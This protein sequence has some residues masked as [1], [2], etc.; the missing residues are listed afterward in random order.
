MVG[1]ND[2]S[3]CVGL[4]RLLLRLH[5]SIVPPIILGFEV[6]DTT[7]VR[8]TE[9]VVDSYFLA[10]IVVTFRTCTRT[11]RRNGSRRTGGCSRAATCSAGLYRLVSSVPWNEVEAA[12]LGKGSDERFPNEVLHFIR[13][14][15]LI[16]VARP[17]CCAIRLPGARV[18][19]TISP[20]LIKLFKLLGAFF[21]TIHFLTCAY[22]RLSDAMDRDRWGRS[23]FPP[24]HQLIGAAL[25]RQ[26]AYGF[27]WVILA[28]LGNAPVDGEYDQC[29]FAIVCTIIGVLVYAF[30]VGTAAGLLS[31]M[32]ALAVEKKEKMDFIN[33][34]MMVKKLPRK[35]QDKVRAYYDYVFAST[36]RVTLSQ[37][38]DAFEDLPEPL[39]LR[40]RLL[41]NAPSL[42][43]TQIFNGE[44]IAPGALEL[45]ALHLR[46][47][48]AF[49]GMVIVRERA[50]MDRVHFPHARLRA[51]SSATAS[52]T[53]ST[54]R[55]TRVALADRR[56]EAAA[57]TTAP[58]ARV[59]A[60]PALAHRA[61]R[62]RRAARGPGS[63][64]P[65]ST[66]RLQRRHSAARR[67]VVIVASYHWRE[68]SPFSQHRG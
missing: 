67:R 7:S 22:W 56:A 40:L 5:S 9:P 11:P 51:L 10:D 4:H 60:R 53:A 47:L 42:R 12:V 13:L 2:S 17:C 18:P 6:P 23:D 61:A 20:S 14:L 37:E 35:L 58:T 65:T 21:L 36:G 49:K 30:I 31:E 64:A 54:T 34:Y 19:G 27:L 1:E 3:T 16:K 39:A 25:K 24:P 29:V 8:V 62:E 59:A 45:F 48:I 68:L 26:Y 50:P 52:V 63:A 46:P 38:H 32:N 57:S 44:G 43:R 66:T 41:E 55:A 28:T 15:K 33:K